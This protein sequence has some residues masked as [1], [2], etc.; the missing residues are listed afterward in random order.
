M[1]EHPSGPHARASRCCCVSA[2]LEELIGLSDT[3]L[4]ILRGRIVATLDPATVT[5]VELGSY[6]TG[7]KEG[8]AA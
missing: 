2:D 8:T 7:A 6:M 1:G 4:V 3:L 5:P